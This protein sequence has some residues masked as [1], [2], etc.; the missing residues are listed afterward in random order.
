MRFGIGIPVRLGDSLVE[1]LHERTDID[2]F[3]CG[4]RN[5]R[6]IRGNGPFYERLDLVIVVDSP[7]SG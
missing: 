5:N 3:L 7:L 4:D 6:G 2:S 1:R